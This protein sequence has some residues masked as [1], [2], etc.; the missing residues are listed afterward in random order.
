MHASLLQA[1]NESE[2]ARTLREGFPWLRFG[3]QLEREF[4]TEHRESNRS[5]IQISV[6]LALLT[7]TTF[8]ILDRWL[9]GQHGSTPDAV[10]FGLHLPI[11]IVC[12]ALTTA[13]FYRWY[14]PV[15]HIGAPIFGLGTV[16]LASNASTDAGVSLMYARLVL[17]TFFFYFMLGLSFY[18]ALRTNLVVFFGSAIAAIVGDVSP[19]IALYQ[20]FVV[21][22]ANLF[23][24]AGCYALEHA[25]R[26]AFL[27]RRLLTEVATHD[28]LTGLK[29]RAAFEAEIRRVWLQA[30][31]DRQP[32]AIV[33][34]DIDHFKAFNDR[35]GH[36]AGDQCL[37]DV[38]Q[39][40]RR[41]AVRCP[42]D[43]VARYGGEEMIA[44]LPACELADAQTLARAMLAE[45]TQLDIPHASSLTRPHVTISV[46]VASFVPQRDSSHDVAVLA[47]DRALYLAKGE[48]RDRWATYDVLDDEREMRTAV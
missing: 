4:V 15:I 34:I 20:M 18:A 8:A 22:C 25:N 24:G 26:L 2:A 12:L 31:R 36:L 45:V 40:V 23:A 46:G 38:A 5:R 19:Q 39:A 16:L 42:G 32:V 17:A 14:W 6:F 13:R 1:G 48:G 43:V 41:A 29:N 3:P 47:A 44:V 11:V 7:V 21:L 33:M 37:R 9:M 28:G 30:T 10:R 35:Y 27:D